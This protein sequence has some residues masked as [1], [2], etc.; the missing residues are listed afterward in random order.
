MNDQSNEGQVMS[1]K[2][3]SMLLNCTLSKPRSELTEN[4]S[5]DYLSK[6]GFDP[7]VMSNVIKNPRF[8]NVLEKVLAAPSGLVRHL[9]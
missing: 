2:G 8:A 5:L 1:Y 4:A 6:S 9:I 3:G 7:V